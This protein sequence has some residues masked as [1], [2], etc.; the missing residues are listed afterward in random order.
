[1]NMFYLFIKFK[2]TFNDNRIHIKLCGIAIKISAICY[3]YL[4]VHSYNKARSKMRKKENRS[5]KVVF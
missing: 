1:M 4:H 5:C 2:D 3:M